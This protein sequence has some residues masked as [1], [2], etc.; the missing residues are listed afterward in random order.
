VLTLLSWV[1][2]VVEDGISRLNQRQDDQERRAIIDWL[3]PID[4]ASQQSDFISRRQEGTGM[5]LLNSDEF[6]EW[7]G[8]SKKTLFCPGIPGAGKTMMTSIVVDFLNV[9]FE[10]DPG[11]AIAY[12][13]CNYQLQQTQ[14]PEDL[15]SSLLKQ[16]VQEQPALRIDVKDLCERHMTKGTRPSFDEIVKVFRSTVQLY[17]RVFIIIDALDEYHVSSEGQNR[18]LS[19]L[20]NL[21][22]IAQVNL[23]ATS[24]FISEITSQFEGC[25]VKEIRGQDDDVLSYV[26]GR[27]PQ[28]L[29]SQ[30]SKHP[31]VQDEIREAIVKAVHGMYVHSSVSIW[32]QPD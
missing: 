31:H 24:R 28:L 25:I 8:Q 27:I 29:R 9:K 32:P 11:V 23:F 15:L 13:Y 19:E 16:L 4:Y 21:Q 6:Q 3:T 7:L 10:K 30:I 14:R 17:S 26:N 12:T 22:V 5:W 2:S 20:F 1:S 18:L